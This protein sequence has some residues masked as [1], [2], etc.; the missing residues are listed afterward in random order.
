MFIFMCL[1]LDFYY[2]ADGGYRFGCY[3]ANLQVKFC[4]GTD[5]IAISL[6]L[7]LRQLVR[8]IEMT[9]A[10][11][12]F[13]YE[14]LI[15]FLMKLRYQISLFH[16]TAT[17][18]DLYF[19]CSIDNVPPRKFSD[20]SKNKNAESYEEGAWGNYARGAVLAL[21]KRGYNLTEV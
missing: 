21:Q 17:W 8:A 9:A 18:V 2:F 19:C 4:S 15:D 16:T 14:R 5:R 6:E 3:Q 13:S 1:L 12:F 11:P 10:E 7:S 20:D